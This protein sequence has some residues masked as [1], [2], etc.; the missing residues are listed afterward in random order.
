LQH[1]YQDGLLEAITAADGIVL[2]EAGLE[3][4]IQV[5]RNHRLWELYLIEYADVA[6]SRVD[7]DADTLEHVLGEQMVGELE[8][9][10]QRLR[11]AGTAVVP[12]SPHPIQPG[13]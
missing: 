2:S 12:P 4:A 5:T 1:A 11:M 13:D 6:P 8:A 3:A 10:L 9:K 7:R